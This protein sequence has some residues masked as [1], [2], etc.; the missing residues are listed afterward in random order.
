[1]RPGKYRGILENIEKSCFRREII[2]CCNKKKSQVQLL[3]KCGLFV[4]IE[5]ITDF[6]C[7]CVLSITNCD[8]QHKSFQSGFIKET[9]IPPNLIHTHT[10]D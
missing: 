8:A 4:K 10:T 1:M 6:K 3:I 5:V 7:C 9:P 2:T